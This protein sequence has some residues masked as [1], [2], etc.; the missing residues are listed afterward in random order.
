MVSKKLKEILEHH[1]WMI[2]DEITPETSLEED[3][4]LDDTDMLLMV[5]DLEDTFDVVVT[6]AD[7]ESLKT[8]ADVIRVVESKQ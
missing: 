5:T 6:D 3:F 8:V 1:S 4:G 2:P 7:I